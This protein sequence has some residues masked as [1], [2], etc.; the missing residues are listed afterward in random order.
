MLITSITIGTIL[1]FALLLAV[2]LGRVFRIDLKPGDYTHIDGLRAVAALMVVC[3]H[4][5]AHTALIMNAAADIR[6]IE[7]LGAV[8]VQ[9]FFCITGFLFTRKAL[10]KPI[11][12]SELIA[13]R[14]RRIVPLYVF[15]MTAAIAV[16]VFI[17]T[18]ANKAE[19]VEVI[20]VVRAY[21][22]GFF[23]APIPTVAGMSIG[24][25]AGQMWTLAWEWRFY[26]AVPFIGALVARRAWGFAAMAFAV[27]CLVVDHG[28]YN[29]VPPWAFFVPGV[30][31]ALVE[32]RADADERFR[33]GL[34]AA[35]AVAFL[36]ALSFDMSLNG[37]AQTLL[38]SVGFACVLFGHRAPLSFRPIRLLGEVSYSVYLL[39]L[40]IASV[41][42]MYVQN[43]SRFM[44]YQTP[45]EKL[46]LAVAALAGLFVLSFA[47]Y[48]L[49]ERP[50]M[51]QSPSGTTAS[52]PIVDVNALSQ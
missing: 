45:G 43:E 22:Y 51:R 44:F 48:A 15:V 6:L 47:T 19:T 1:L 38:C 34:S 20:D 29:A 42:W 5:L 3:S 26:L 18:S 30:V 33:M 11:V 12:V 8:G 24:G 49:I 10:N 32:K 25:Q 40:I 28:L 21:A 2:P 36:A 14:I 35:G 16:A 17:A 31:C 39:H 46:P 4:Y 27:G 7:A 50:F 52:S 41:F 23:V 13:S 37:Y 9:I